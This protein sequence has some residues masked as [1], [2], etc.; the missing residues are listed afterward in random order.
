[1]ASIWLLY[2]I[3][4]LN[5]AMQAKLNGAPDGSLAYKMNVIPDIY[6]AA[7]ITSAL[8]LT[9]IGGMLFPRASKEDRAFLAVLVLLMLPMNAL[10]FHCVRMPIDAWL[11]TLLGESSALYQFIYCLYAPFTEEPA[12][13][14]PLLI[15]WI[16]SRIG[17]R[18]LVSVAFAIGLGFGVG[19]AWTVA[20]L[21]SKSPEIAMYPWYML[22]GYIGERMLV[23]VMH[24]AFT[25]VALY[26]IIKR[27]AVIT[28]LLSAMLLHF[29]GNFPIFLAQKNLFSIGANAWMVIL[30]IWV[31]AYLFLSGFILAYLAYGKQWIHKLLKMKCPECGNIYQRPI[32]WFNVNL[33]HKCYERCPYCKHWHLVNNLPP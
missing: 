18:N 25:G 33:F 28:G 32:L 17:S 26:F 19:E 2:E 11:S 10:A 6:I 24:A 7:I 5:H 3:G 15:P 16:Y 1:M 20:G 21:L 8:S 23:C 12:K 31:L 13:L 22:G 29:I 9:T 4:T 27:K 14:W 30:Q